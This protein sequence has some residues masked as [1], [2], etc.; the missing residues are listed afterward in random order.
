MKKMLLSIF[1][2]SLLLSCRNETIENNAPVKS[3]TDIV[4]N[5]I[6]TRRAIRK[7]KTQQVGRGKLDTILKCAIYAPSALNKQPWEIRAIQNPELLKKINDRFLSFA[8][9]KTFQGSAAHYKEPG[10]S[11]FH[12]SPTLIVIARDKSSNISYMDCGILLENILLSA[13]AT[14]L[15][16]CPLGTLVPVLNRPENADLLELMN[17]PEGYEVAINVS[18]G[19]SD[20]TPPVKKKYADRVKI[21]E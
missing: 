6:L 7:Y 5:N 20:E 13:H 17:I 15:G 16:T 1:C 9:G 21:I 2:I 14:G 4:I 19:Y 10:F 8:E 3:E 18:L 12:N 11:I